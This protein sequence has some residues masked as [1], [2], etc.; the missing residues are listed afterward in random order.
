MGWWEDNEFDL[1]QLKNANGK[2][3]KL[4]ENYKEKVNL[5]K[6][7][8]VKLN[9]YSL[10]SSMQHHIVS[11]GRGKILKYNKRAKCLEIDLPKLK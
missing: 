3:L 9:F 10:F 5:S 7:Y 4:L 11:G 6:N 2:S 1:F 8:R